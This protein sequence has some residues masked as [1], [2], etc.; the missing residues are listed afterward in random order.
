MDQKENRNK[1]KSVN[2][3]DLTE[4][5]QKK[6]ILTNITRISLMSENREITYDTY[7]FTNSKNNITVN[8]H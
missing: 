2:T 5:K 1:G 3:R 7:L 4:N 6:K 8:K